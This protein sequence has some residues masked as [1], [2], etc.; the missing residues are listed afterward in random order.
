MY[1]HLPSLGVCVFPSRVLGPLIAHS[2]SRECHLGDG[3][4]V[5]A[6]SK[7]LLGKLYYLEGRKAVS[8]AQADRPMVPE[9]I[10]FSFMQASF[11]SYLARVGEL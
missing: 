1:N 2:S 7:Q 11:F 5:R 4:A 3:R 9:S 8:P 10:C 6:V